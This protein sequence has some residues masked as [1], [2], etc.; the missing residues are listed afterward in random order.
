[1]ISDW[2]TAGNPWDM[3]EHNW[4]ALI[5]MSTSKTIKV[6]H[7]SGEMGWKWNGVN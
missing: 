3:D 1:M 7:K 5:A 4:K 2:E 6:R